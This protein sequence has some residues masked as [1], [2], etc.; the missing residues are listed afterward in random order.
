MNKNVIVIIGGF[1]LIVILVSVVLQAMFS[2]SD[3]VQEVVIERSEPKVRVLVAAQDLPA[4]TDV[5]GVNIMWQEW[6]EDGVFPG[7][8]VQEGSQAVT[9]V[10][11]GRLKISLSEG[12]PVMLSALVDNEGGDN[13]A[14]VLKKGMRAVSIEVKES[15]MVAGFVGPGDHVDVLMTYTFDESLSDVIDADEDPEMAA[16][17]AEN[18]DRR[19]TEVVLENVRVLAVDQ[20][21][22][23]DEENRVRIGNTVTLEVTRKGAETLAL[24]NAVGRLSLALRGIGDDEELGPTTKEGVTTDTRMITLDQEIYKGLLSLYKRR[25]EEGLIDG[26]GE[27]SAGQRRK[28]MRVYR[29]G[30][31]QDYEVSPGSTRTSTQ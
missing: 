25:L 19:A 26:N 6:P 22:K 10:A 9:D 14:A 28:Y 13:L 11:K 5:D 7:A 15:E 29:G 8:V 21:A 1:L 27:N 23:P 2:G 24:A 3:K 12:E 30:S 31:V 16:Y 17:V 4:G 20:R 18:I